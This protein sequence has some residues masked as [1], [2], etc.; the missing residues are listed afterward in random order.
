MRKPPC[1]VVSE[2]PA[3]AM[4]DAGLALTHP[5]ITRAQAFAQAA[6]EG[7]GSQV[8]STVGMGAYD[9]LTDGRMGGQF[10]KFRVDTAY[11]LVASAV[12]SL[13]IV[14]SAGWQLR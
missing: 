9:F 1:R 11:A 4:A 13:R 6:V 10:F 12:A 8:R 3:G 5:L 2:L 14:F 7:P